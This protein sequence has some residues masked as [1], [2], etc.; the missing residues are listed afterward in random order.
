LEA[1]ERVQGYVTT[2]DV[3]RGMAGVGAW[4]GGLFGLLAGAAFLWVPGLGPL[5]V[6]GPLVTGLLGALEGGALDGL[7]GAI[8]GKQIEDKRLLKY[9]ADLK[10]GKWLVTVHGT[11]QELGTARRVMAENSGQ[12]VSLYQAA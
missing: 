6:L 4:T 7:L 1:V 12:D 9:Q 11:P 5:V 10:A 8:L 3:A 2:G